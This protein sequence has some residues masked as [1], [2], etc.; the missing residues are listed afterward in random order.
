[1]RRSSRV[2]ARTARTAI[3]AGLFAGV[4]M[5]PFG[6]ALRALGQPVN[7]YGELVVRSVLGSAPML[8]LLVFHAIVS[9]G[10]AVPFVALVSRRRRVALGAGY[11][12]AAWAVLNATLLPLWF[13]RPT[14]WT[15]G[16][17]EV[18]ASL[19]VHVVY[20]IVLAVASAPTPEDGD[21]R[22]PDDGNL[23][24]VGSA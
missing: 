16:F 19:V 18:W 6:V 5:T 20:G 8:A 10:L 11:G 2:I 12:I 14:A 4:S 3:R 24:A 22:G 13:G 15:L 1:M 23:R 21:R 7:V 9:I 17:G